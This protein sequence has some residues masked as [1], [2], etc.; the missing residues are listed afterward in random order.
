[1]HIGSVPGA[2]EGKASVWVYGDDVN[3]VA[4][5]ASL[6]GA[7]EALISVDTWD[8]A[9]GYPADLEYGKCR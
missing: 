6:A 1:M 2:Q 3:I 7:G 4:R 9:G 8:A 5:L